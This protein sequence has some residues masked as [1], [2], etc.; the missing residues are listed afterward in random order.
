MRETAPA[1]Y[2]KIRARC[3]IDEPANEGLRHLAE[4]PL[5]S[6]HQFLVANQ[7]KPEDFSA[8]S[9]DEVKPV[10]SAAEAHEMRELWGGKRT[11]G[12]FMAHY[13]TIRFTEHITQEQMRAAT[14]ASERVHGAAVSTFVNHSDHQLI[15][16]GPMLPQSP[17]WFEIGLTRATTMM[18]S[19]DWMYQMQA[20]WGDGL[21]G[22]VGFLVDILRAGAS[23]HDLPIGFY[24]TF[25]QAD[26]L[27]LKTLLGIAHGVKTVYFWDYGPTY[28]ATENFWSDS[29]ET[30]TGVA[31]IT[32]EVAFADEL[33]LAGKPARA[34][35]GLVYATTEDI[36]EPILAM[37]IERQ[38]LHIAL[39][40]DRY[41]TD[42]LNETLILE[43]DLAQYQ[44]IY[45]ADRHIPLACQTKLAQWVDAG[46]TLAL[47]PEAGTR[48]E[49]D[50]PSSIIA[51]LS[52]TSVQPNVP[53]TTVRRTG[54]EPTPVSITFRPCAWTKKGA[55]AL[56][57]VA[58]FADGSPAIETL[59]VGKGSCVL[60]RFMPGN[61]FFK[62]V[63]ALNANA[64]VAKYP[65]AARA[66]IA[67]PCRL[68]KVARQVTLSHAGIGAYVL[69]G[70]KGAALIL[71]NWPRQQIDKL[72]VEVRIDGIKTVMSHRQGAVTSSIKDGVVS[73]SIP[74][75]LTDIVALQR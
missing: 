3:I 16:H 13:W 32:R 37:S 17:D 53:T 33:I 11:G 15:I 51:G 72:T 43:R 1:D 25:D 50:R 46:G 42:L 38:L 34:K 64:I 61:S 70:P 41:V 59:A 28:A 9:W 39:D 54:A 47:M 40:Q 23:K 71:L 31:E 22:R 20:S 55:P 49:Y 5:A 57:P 65:E 4:Q 14:A 44:V 24:N 63:A 60:Y 52:A 27:R 66:L 48:D 67:E 8:K 12:I 74:L 73:F 19:E 2:A 69:D 68:A 26:P 10:S 45:L 18:W 29:R 36:W 6:F 21:L 7:L 75:G 58:T 62:Q 35:V 56:K 30:Y